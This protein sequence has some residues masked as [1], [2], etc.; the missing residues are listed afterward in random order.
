MQRRIISALIK[1]SNN[2]TFTF[3]SIKVVQFSLSHISSTALLENKVSTSFGCA[4]S[5]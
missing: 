4:V 5:L 2:Q 1:K 3:M